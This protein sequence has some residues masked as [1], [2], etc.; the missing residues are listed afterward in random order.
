MSFGYQ[1]SDTYFV[2]ISSK[3]IVMEASILCKLSHK[4]MKSYE[5][6]T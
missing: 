1:K 4:T 5:M 2:S 6:L 3:A